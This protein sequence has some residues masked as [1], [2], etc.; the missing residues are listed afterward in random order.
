MKKETKY[1]IK[2]TPEISFMDENVRIE[3]IGNPEESLQLQMTTKDYYNI[4]G[5]IRVMDVGSQWESIIEIKLD[6]DGIKVFDASIFT[7]MHIVEGK[8]SKLE[9]D[10]AKLQENRKCHIDIK[11]YKGNKVITENL[12]ERVFC[13][14]TVISKNVISNQLLARYFTKS[15]SSKC[16]TIIVVSGSDGRIE[17]AQAIAQCLAMK[18]FSTLALCYFG[19]DHVPNDLDRIQMEY[20]KNAIEWLSKQPEV[21][22]DR[23]G[24]YGRSKGGEM[25]L[26]AATLF[27]QLK[28]VVANTPSNYVN[29]GII[30][31]S[32]T[33]GHSS[34]CFGDN[35]I[36]FI[37][38]S[39]RSLL[40]LMIGLI[41][42]NPR[43]FR[44]FYQS[45][46]WKHS[47]AKHP[48]ARIM[49]EKSNASFLLIASD[50]DGIWPSDSYIKDA[51]QIMKDNEKE[52][53]CKQFCYSGAGHMLTLPYQPIPNC[54]EYGGTIENAIQATIGSWKETV[55]FLVS[56]N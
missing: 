28:Y 24:I 26:L 8:K 3:I 16:P 4:N 35:E 27:P 11:L 29:E 23:I 34:W 55:Q 17:K 7:T 18:G 6:G 52:K 13:D 12:H 53:Y 46:T 1:Q 38:T 48:D 40:K 2:I 30:G 54:E 56:S 5:D 15:N 43:A 20:L 25:V 36:P 49:I 42:K 45:L 41:K 37:K 19:M 50:T 39:K 32:R 21:D 10:L 22:A 9:Q 44:E 33:S 51:Y 31:G 47:N 14:D